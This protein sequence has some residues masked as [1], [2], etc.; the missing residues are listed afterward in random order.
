M[1][2]CAGAANAQSLTY[3]LLIPN[4]AAAKYAPSVIDAFTCA[5]NPAAAPFIRSFSVGVSA[6]NRFLTDELKLVTVA[7][8]VKRSQ[9][10]ISLLLRH[11]GNIDYNENTVGLNYGFSLGKISLG[12]IFNYDMLQVR[13]SPPGSH[14]KYGVASLWQISK[15]VFASFQLTNPHFFPEGSKERSPT[16][17]VTQFG[18]GYAPSEE[19]YVAVESQKEEDKPPQAIFVICYQY[20]GKYFFNGCWATGAH[21]PYIGT[22]WQW[23]NLRVETGCAFHQVLGISPSLTILY[24][25]NEKN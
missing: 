16:A 12:A 25:K 4:Q 2:C 8:A 21:Q 9:S 20:A 1:L 7:A 10:G 3:P 23:K 13:G 14:I 19:F 5:Y 24:V 15:K 6:E 11:F 22:G 18:V 17:T